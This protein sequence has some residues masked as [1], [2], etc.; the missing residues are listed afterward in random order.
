[1][2]IQ[3]GQNSEISLPSEELAQVEAMLQFCYRF[4]FDIPADGGH[5]LW[6][7]SQVFTFADKYA[8]EDLAAFCD[9]RFEQIIKDHPFNAKLAKAIRHVYIS[10]PSM[11]QELRKSVV[12]K[13]AS[14]FE[15]FVQ[16]PELKQMMD[17]HGELGREIAVE[18]AQLLQKRRY[19]RLATNYLAGTRFRRLRI[20]DMQDDDDDDAGEDDDESG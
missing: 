10:T 17:D 14:K 18:L 9:D 15:G 1:M 13:A 20:E 7:I 3:E 2:Q 5:G 19:Y 16:R 6:H 8:I 4:K 12:K 11:R